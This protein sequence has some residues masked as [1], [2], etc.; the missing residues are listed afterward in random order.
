MTFSEDLG[1]RQY[2]SQYSPADKIG[3]V[4]HRGGVPGDAD[5][6]TV[7]VALAT[8]D[9]NTDPPTGTLFFNREADHVAEGTYET[10]LSSAETATPGLYR[11][12]WTYTL[13]AVPQTYV[14][15]VEVGRASPGY[16]SLSVGFKGV[17][18]SA[19]LRFA[20][21][22]DSPYGGPHL[23]VYFQ[24]R[25]DRGRMADMM[26]LAMN[27]LN[28]MAQPHMTYSVDDPSSPFPISQWGGLLDTLTYIEAVKHLRRSYVEQPLAEGVTVSRLDRR[29][30]MVRWGEILRDEEADVKGSI[31]TFKIAH[32]GLGRP[33]V[34]V[35]GGVY[36]NFGPTRLIG[37]AAA[38]PRYWAVW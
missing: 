26:R 35:S 32:M 37:S 16:D 4:V 22:F 33:R 1:A 17:V 20:D 36:G 15:I 23:Q 34:L 27:R 9:Y 30:Y 18:E 13:D 6:N 10:T 12:T 24:A 5:G 38:R 25:W 19:W 11:A 31:D 3:I 7:T 21:L 29:D 2:V 8:L 14:G 28:T